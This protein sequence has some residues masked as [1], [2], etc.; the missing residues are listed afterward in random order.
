MVPIVIGR[1]APLAILPIQRDFAV[2]DQS[3]AAESS[4]A[5]K[6]AASRR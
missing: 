1:G 5:G 4:R 2:I 6:N 3:K